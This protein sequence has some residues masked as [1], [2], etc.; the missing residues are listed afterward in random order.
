MDATATDVAH[1][2]ANDAKVRWLDVEGIVV[3]VVIIAQP[4]G[5][6]QG[7]GGRCPGGRRACRGVALSSACRAHAVLHPELLTDD[8]DA[9]SVVCASQPGQADAAKLKL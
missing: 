7:F 8:R 2:R 5:G 3:L 9:I 6:T 4:V 1:Q